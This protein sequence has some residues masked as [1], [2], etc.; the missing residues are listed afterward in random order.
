M[1]K[2][3]G[4]GV[5]VGMILLILTIPSALSA[6]CPEG[7]TCLT[8]ENAKKLGY[9]YCQ[10]EKILC[11][12]DQ[13]KNPMYCY[14]LPVTTTPSCPVN[15]SCLTQDEAKKLG[16]VY[17][18]NEQIVC[19]Y[20]SYQNPKYCFEKPSIT[21]TPTTPTPT[22]PT[23][24]SGKPD[25]VILDVWGYGDVEGVYTEIRYTIQNIGNATA[26]AST[27]EIYIDSIKVAEHSIAPLNAS[28]VRVERVAYN[29]TCS[30]SSD[31]FVAKADAQN[32]V[33]ELNEANNKYLRIY[34]CPTTIVKPDFVVVD[35]WQENESIYYCKNRDYENNIK[36]RVTNKGNASASA[37][38]GLYIDGT[39]VATRSL[40]ILAPGESYEG[41]FTYFGT[42]S[43]ASDV[44]EVYVDYQRL[45]SEWNEDNNALL[46]SFNCFVSP[47]TGTPDLV[48]D[49]T[50]WTM[51]RQWVYK[52]EYRIT[53][54]GSGYACNFTVGVFNETWHLIAT[55]SVER[56]APMESKLEEF[57]TWRY[58]RSRCEDSQDIIR[59]VADYANEIAEINETNNIH[60]DVWD[61]LPPTPVIKPDLVITEVHYSPPSS[62]RDLSISYTITN[63][64]NVAC[65]A[66]QT[67][68]WINGQLISSD[69]VPGLNNG[70]SLTRTFAVRWTPTFKENR[71]QICA[72]A[73]NQVDEITPPPSGE[74]NNC[75]TVTWNF[76]FSCRNGV[77][78]GDETGVDCGGSLCPPCGNCR[79]GAKWAPND[80]PCTTHW[81]TDEGPTIG[82]N[83]E[84]DSCA[85]VEVCH[86][87]LDYIV[88]D[89]I[90]C[91][92]N[93]NFAT[94]FAGTNRESG[95]ISACQYARDKSG[96]NVATTAIS[97]K[98]CL[99]FYAIQSLG[100]GA[101]Y[102]QGYFDGEFSC[103]GDPT[104]EN[105]PK[106]KVKPTAWEMGTSASCA[107]PYGA[108]PDFMMGGH[109]CE[110]YDAWIFGKYGKHGYWKSDTDFRKNSDSAADVP[111]HASI[112][113]LSTG[114]CVDYS[115]ALTTLL[116]RLGYSKDEVFSVNG[117]GH[118]YNLVK[119][120]GETK[121]HY[122]DTVGN[123][124]GGVYGGTGFPAIYNST[125]HLVAWYDYCKN[126]D[127][128][129]SNDYYS[130][131]VSNCPP[132]SQIYSCEG[133]SR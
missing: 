118:G 13:F 86:P 74:L 88:D 36:F 46:K 14:Q 92:E 18:R 39:L 67:K 58:D 83:T 40:P 111:A 126:M 128:G 12:Y 105:C 3:F 35:F 43:G 44:I 109:R 27:T 77:R 6:V 90:A 80:S 4:I 131:S 130:E 34:S 45:V 29:G 123:N 5:L 71:V 75:L 17:C 133:V 102:M 48:I 121:W 93:S 117:D 125:G 120:P 22:T 112:N 21:P 72:D 81:P 89:A 73:N 20:D 76:V 104:A 54:R 1:K 28:E 16:Y 23:T 8:E 65:G 38:A 115:F 82:M 129:C 2:N 49:Y 32:V 97:F 66:S 122:V 103:Y 30:G 60:T 42:C 33:D 87:G 100:Y 99:G 55:D 47:S 51:L 62:T 110:Y 9:A 84:D 127:E 106:W 68:I 25:L 107:G 19:G 98:K 50:R 94:I 31:E 78:D 10:K 119:F 26:G 37:E 56:L 7:C 70:E 91:C 79:T 69:N 132:N 64:G 53:N 124:G 61:C 101:V 57:T 114:T 63:Q 59:L 95:K 96:I 41:A 15:C 116:R 113:L 85:I 108:R 52:L 11:G 24:P